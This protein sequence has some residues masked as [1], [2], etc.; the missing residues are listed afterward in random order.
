MA[1]TGKKSADERVLEGIDNA[2]IQTSGALAPILA[3]A[4]AESMVP[5]VFEGALVQ[6]SLVGWVDTT[7]RKTLGAGPQAVAPA[8]ADLLVIVG[9][10]AQKAA[11]V[12][13]RIFSAMAEPRLVLHIG[14]PTEEEV[15]RSYA[16]VDRVE[17]VVPVDVVVEGTR[18]TQAQLAECLT[19]LKRAAQRWRG[20]PVLEETPAKDVE[21]AP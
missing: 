4:D 11:P 2:A 5:L 8:Q 15:L 20:T 6:S 21:G 17:E 7:L 14:A 19:A 12:L 1:D 16:V 18:P 13:Q 9:A 3:W 10:V